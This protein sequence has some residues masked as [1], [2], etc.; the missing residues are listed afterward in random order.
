MIGANISAFPCNILELK[1]GV[2]KPEV[3]FSAV[4]VRYCF[5]SFNSLFPASFLPGRVGR[6]RTVLPGTIYFHLSTLI[7]NLPVIFNQIF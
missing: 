6:Q 2:R 1:T 7:T 5:Q 4:L 3:Y